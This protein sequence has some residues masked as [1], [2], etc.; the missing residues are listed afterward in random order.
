MHLFDDMC[1]VENVD[2]DFRPVP[3]GEMGSRLLVTNLFNR[4]QPLI[5]FEV[6]D[7]VAIEPE[8]CPCGRTLTRLRS[9][10]GRTED[11]LSLGGVAVH[12]LQFGVVTADPTCA[13]SRWCRRGSALRLRV[14]LRDGCSGGE[15]RLRERVL[16]R[17]RRARGAAARRERGARDALERSPAGKVQIVVAEPSPRARS[18]R[19]ARAARTPVAHL[20]Q[21]QRGQLHQQR[22]AALV[23][24][25]VEHVVA[26]ELARRPPRRC[27]RRRGCS[28]RAARAAR[29]RAPRRWPGGA[30]RTRP[31]RSPRRFRAPRPTARSPRPRTAAAQRVAGR[32][33][34]LHAAGP[35]ARSGRRA[36]RPAG[37]PARA[38]PPGRGSRAARWP[39]RRAGSARPRGAA[40]RGGV[41]SRFENGSSSS[42]S[43]GPGRQRP[44]ERHA[45]ALAAGELV[46]GA[47]SP[48]AAARPARA[49]G[50]SVPSRSS[51]GRVGQ[52]ERHVPLHGQVREQRV[53][54]EDHP[55]LPLL[56]RHHPAR[57]GHHLV[58]ARPRARVRAAR[59]RRSS[60]A[61]S[62]CR[63][64]TGRARPAARRARCRGSARA[65]PSPTPNDFD[66]PRIRTWLMRAPPRA[67]RPSPA[68][69]GEA[70]TSLAPTRP[71]QPDHHRHRQQAH[72]HDHQRRQRRRLVQRLVGGL[73]HGDRHACRRRAGAAGAWR[74][75]PSS[76]RR[77]RAAPP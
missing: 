76:P 23:A 30:G 17:A 12:P 63:S 58:R 39:R 40:R 32:A 18:P 9:L 71:G 72:Q 62:S 73:P 3:D 29:P 49:C 69:A 6:T 21:L 43:S 25:A 27:R 64:P 38:P 60:A 13:S 1:I 61:A 68:A 56:R 44:C 57:P 51:R 11:V 16:R 15:E 14:A 7:L 66:S 2:D 41:A 42:T 24:Q 70:S 19:P 65:R 26:A 4:A 45:L 59:S 50:G 5:R 28:A 48:C 36:S 77:T 31:A 75:A 52:P 8:P 34:H 53:V 33:V 35:P 74:A 54:L 20:V 22:L 47:G 46:H 37:R 67:R 10:E 55:H